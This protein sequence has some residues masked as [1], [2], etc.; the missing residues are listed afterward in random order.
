MP[1]RLDLGAGALGLEDVG[2][3]A[4]EV[5]DFQAV[6]RPMERE[7]IAVAARIAAGII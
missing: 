2:K 1:D 4:R 5:A 7:V 6:N 3:A